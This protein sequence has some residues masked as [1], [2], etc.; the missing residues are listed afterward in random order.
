M[1]TFH[2]TF[3]KC[4]VVTVFNTMV[5]FSIPLTSYVLVKAAEWLTLASVLI[6]D[7]CVLH[8]H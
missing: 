2:L 4:A 7:E 8:M 5:I 3:F 1:L 6:T